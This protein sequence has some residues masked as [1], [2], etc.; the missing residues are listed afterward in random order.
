MDET[1]K[2]ALEEF[3]K[4]KTNSEDCTIFEMDASDQKLAEV[5]FELVSAFKKGTKPPPIYFYEI[6]IYKEEPI[7]FGP[8]LK[9]YPREKLWRMIAEHLGFKMLRE[10]G[11]EYEKSKKQDQPL[12][13]IDVKA[14]GNEDE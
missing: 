1:F 14:I 9:K 13:S 4:K 12:V 2:K 3:V 5:F 6:K 10:R 11:D 8:T 7:K